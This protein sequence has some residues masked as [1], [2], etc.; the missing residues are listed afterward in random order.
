M[1]IK[2]LIL[3]DTQIPGGKVIQRFVGVRGKRDLHIAAQDMPLY[4]ANGPVIFISDA[5]LG[6]KRFKKSSHKRLHIFCDILEKNPKASVVL[7]GDFLEYGFNKTKHLKQ[8]MEHRKSKNPVEALWLQMI[9]ILEQREV[10]LLGGNHDP[11]DWYKRSKWLE[12]TGWAI[13]KFVI[14]QVKEQRI[15]LTHGHDIYE[16]VDKM[17]FKGIRNIHYSLIKLARMVENKL[18]KHFG[19]KYLEW[20]YGHMNHSVKEVIGDWKKAFAVDKVL[21]GHVHMP[22][23]DQEKH[24]YVSGV[25]TEFYRSYALVDSHGNISIDSQI[26]KFNEYLEY[27]KA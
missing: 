19:S 13:E 10:I 27:Q 12:H 7:G 3:G 2:S 4:R 1:K 15:L 14:L 24:L 6:V 16:E 26:I 8:L 5:H 17:F 23:A 25:F 21:M 11:H 9:T 22:Y 20:S 18:L